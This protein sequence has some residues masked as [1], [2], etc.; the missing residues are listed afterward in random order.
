MERNARFRRRLGIISV[1]AAETGN[2]RDG[3]I[4]CVRRWL[5]HVP[6]INTFFKFNMMASSC[7]AFP[8]MGSLRGW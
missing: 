6:Y 8:H 1:I 7:V 2:N 4:C 5:K 3:A